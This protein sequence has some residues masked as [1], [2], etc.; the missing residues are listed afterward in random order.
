MEEVVFVMTVE[1]LN[2]AVELNAAPPRKVCKAVHE[3]DDADAT[4]PGFTKLIATEPVAFETEM[5]VPEETEPTPTTAPVWP[6]KELTTEVAIR[7]PWPF[8][9][10]TEF[11]MPPKVSVPSD[12]LAA[13]SCVE[14]TVPKICSVTELSDHTKLAVLVTVVVVFQKVIWFAAPAP[15]RMP[16]RTGRLRCRQPRSHQLASIASSRRVR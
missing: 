10:S 3:T 6:L 14:E 2:V 9:A 16:C 5:F 4:K 15:P 8:T 11:E 7:R 13:M 1:L 12:E